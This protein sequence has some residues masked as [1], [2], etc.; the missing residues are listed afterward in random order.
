MAMKILGEICLV[1]V[2]A[3]VFI[4][5]ARGRTAERAA[6]EAA[7]MEY[8]R[9]LDDLMSN[10]KNKKTIATWNYVTNMTQHN[11]EQMVRYSLFKL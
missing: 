2:I 5:A 4:V 10:T 1:G 3:S 9:S 11:E 7:G 8:M 6:E